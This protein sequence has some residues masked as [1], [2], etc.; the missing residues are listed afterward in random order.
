MMQNDRIMRSHPDTD[1][2]EFPEGTPENETPP[3][4]EID[5]KKP[6]GRTKPTDHERLEKLEQRVEEH[7]NPPS[8]K[9]DEPKPK[10][11]WTVKRILITIALIIIMG[12]IVYNLMLWMSY[13]AH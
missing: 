1:L 13:N 9:K 5:R 2:P 3:V 12:E 8:K 6:A 4:I 11:K 10:K 7:I